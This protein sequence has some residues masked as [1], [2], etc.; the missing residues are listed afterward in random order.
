MALCTKNDLVVSFTNLP[1][2]FLLKGAPVLSTDRPVGEELL[3]ELLKMVPLSKS[4][5]VEA[6]FA[7][8]FRQL[9]EI[10]MKALSPGIND[11]GTAMLSLRALFELF[12]FRLEHHPPTE[13]C[14]AEGHVRIRLRTWTFEQ[15]FKGTIHAI[16]DYGSEDRSIRHELLNMLVQLRTSSPVVKVMLERVEAAIAKEE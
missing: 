16:W 10:A 11:P 13:L 5:S 3:V 6:N 15:L 9:T 14:D 7:F 8:G 1:G 2:T 4:E 12:S